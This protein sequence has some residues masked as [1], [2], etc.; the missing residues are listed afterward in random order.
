MIRTF[1][2]DLLRYLP[3]KAFSGIFGILTIP[4]LTRLFKPDDY[5]QYIIVISTVSVL[6]IIASDWIGPS[7]IRFY[8]MY[9]KRL[10]PDVF[11]GTVIRITFFSISAISITTIP[12][13]FYLRT[14]IDESLYR[15]MQIGFLILI[16]GIAFNVM[17]QMLVVKRKA[18]QYSFFSIWR[19]CACILIGLGLVVAF[20]LSIDGLLWGIVLGIVPMLPVLFKMTFGDFKIKHASKGLCLDMRRYGF[21]LVAT[22]L[23]AWIMALSDRYIIEYYRGSHEVGLYSI[24]YSL[25]DR[26]IHLIVSLVLLASAPIVMQIW[27]S[28]GANETRRFLRDLTKYYLIITMP[29]IVCLSLLSESILKLLATSDFLNGYKIMPMVATSIFIFGL[30]RNFQL[31]L[32]F[33]KKTKLVMYVV[34]ISGLINIA[35]NL[36]LVPEYG[37]VAAGYTTLIS[38]FIFA[39]LIII[40]SRRYFVWKF[41]FIT[42]AKVLVSVSLMGAIVHIVEARMES[43]LFTIILSVTIGAF[44]YFLLLIMLKE[45][46]KDVFENILTLFRKA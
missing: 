10:Q 25:A 15:Y 13:L 22:N 24:S 38:Y 7:I 23:A 34:L 41:P 2:K 3:S 28:K 30:Q 26:S 16:F 35:L 11:N 6:A 8:A 5:G 19:Q 31:P 29:V 12:L 44:V 45:I 40:I 42:L 14:H 39:I 37:F 43:S 4:V 17:M 32:L 36:I 27:E 21:P 9:Q 20:K 1:A 18:N 46:N 33:Y